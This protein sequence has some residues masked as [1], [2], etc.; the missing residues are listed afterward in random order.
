[1]NTNFKLQLFAAPT[2]TTTGADIEPAISVDYTTRLA[3]NIASLQELLGI[4]NMI[5][6]AEGSA[7][8]VYKYTKTNTPG[9]AAEGD[10]IE[11]TKIDRKLAFEKTITLKKYRKAVTAEAIQKAGYSNAVN[12][13]DSKLISEV[14]KDIK[15]DFYT[16]IKTGSG[17]AAGTNLQTACANLWAALKKRFEDYDA[18]PVF[19]INPVDVAEYLGTAQITMQTAFG[20]SYIE[21]FLGMGTAIITTEVAEKAPYATAKENLCGAYIPGSGDLAKAFNLTMDPTGMVGMNHSATNS[22][23]T[24]ETL[25]MT[26]ATFWPEYADGVFKATIAP[27]EA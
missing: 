26:G 8:K 2:N 3:S 22:N 5:P 15:K 24:I 23:A 20:F 7:I 1:M 17:S 21:N 16:S 12:E 14:Q 19:F 25:L 4:S 6:M 10:T 13:T 27:A 11:L 9:Q 18:S